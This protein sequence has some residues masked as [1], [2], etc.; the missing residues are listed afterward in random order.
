M[1]NLEKAIGE[2]RNVAEHL[3]T[4]IEDLTCRPI[5]SRREHSDKFAVT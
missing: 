1:F 5:H 2:R 3:K 4:T